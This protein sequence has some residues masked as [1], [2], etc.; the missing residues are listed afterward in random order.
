MFVPRTGLS[1]AQIDHRWRASARARTGLAHGLHA[2]IGAGRQTCGDT[3]GFH[4]RS[5]ASALDGLNAA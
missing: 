4:A 2:A 1:S 3:G 5:I